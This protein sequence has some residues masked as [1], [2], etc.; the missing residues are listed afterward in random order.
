MNN[1]VVSGA[2]IKT[3]IAGIVITHYA[4]PRAADSEDGRLISAIML[5]LRTAE[6]R[7]AALEEAIDVEREVSYKLGQLIDERLDTD[8]VRAQVIAERA[9]TK[10]AQATKKEG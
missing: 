5:A 10:L 7:L 8:R 4:D 2:L 9:A 6:N 1:A 3:E